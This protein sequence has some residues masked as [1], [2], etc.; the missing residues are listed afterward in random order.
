MSNNN[1]N[2]NNQMPIGAPQ[3][4]DPRMA[5]GYGQPAPAG[6]PPRKKHTGLKVLGIIVAF[7]VVLL[8]VAAAV[9]GSPAQDAGSAG[10]TDGE[11]T[12]ALGSASQT[13][14][15]KPKA[16]KPVEQAPKMDCADQEDRNAPCTIHVGKPFALGQHTVQSGWTIKS[17]YLGAELT[18]KAKNTGDHA[19]AMA[20]DVK[21]LKGS[22]VVMAVSCYTD[23]L[24][25]GQVQV[26]KCL[27][28]QEY[29]KKYDRITAEATF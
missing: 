14:T 7:V 25:P 8:V 24:E 19:S 26:M 1:N 28:T 22:E 3:G 23:Q 16:S 2:F 10:L 20:V 12:P 5:D 18:G 13:K 21:F 6:P 11:T 4:Y 27:S 9:G 17:G 15:P 29:T